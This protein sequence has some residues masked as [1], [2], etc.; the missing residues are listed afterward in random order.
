MKR[1]AI[2][3]ACVLSVA[4]LSAQ[5]AGQAGAAGQAGRGRGQ[6]TAPPPINWP[7]PPLPDGPINIDTGLVRP[8]K[9]T[10]TK[11]LT[12]PWSMAFLPDGTMLVTERPGRLR[13]VRKGVLDPTR[14]RTRPNGRLRSASACPART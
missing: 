8:V 10:V 5:Q 13:I 1:I 4:A 12:Q 14:A 9:I 3:S 6:A 2:V 11:G 7:S